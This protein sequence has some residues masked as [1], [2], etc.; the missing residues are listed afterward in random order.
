MSLPLRDYQSECIQAVVNEFNAGVAKQLVVLPT[1]SGKTIIMSGIAKHY[2]RTLLIAHREELL[3]HA[4]DKFKL[5]WPGVSIG[6]V[7]AE[8]NEVDAQI[9]MASVQTAS[10]PRRLEELKEQGFGLL[11]I[12]ESHHA[13]ASSYQDIISG[14]GFSNGND[15]LLVGVTATAMRGDNLG[16]GDLF[17]K[18]TFSRS[19][20]TMIRGGFLSPVIGRRILTNFNFERIKTRNGDYD[21]T[22]LAEAVNTQERN[23]FV[24][25]KFLTYAAERKGVAFCVDVQHCKD[26]ADAFKRAGITCEA[27][28]GAMPTD[29]RKAALEGLKT[30]EIQTLTSCGILCEGFDE[31]TI[32]TILMTRPRRAQVLYSMRRPGIKKI[33]RK[34]KLFSLGFLRPRP[35][36]RFGDDAYPYHPGSLLHQ[37]RGGGSR[38]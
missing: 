27:V 12:D 1:G 36:F 34:R 38:G 23:A 20:A 6:V 29:E 16:L 17:E 28:Y 31:P 26:L 5:F 15:K 7:K 21:L 2:S 22:D 8:R 9:V 11:L 24:V 33:S 4:V 10:R 30:G 19:I 18:I 3:S 14:L 32:D 35:Q 13:M 25:E 37:G